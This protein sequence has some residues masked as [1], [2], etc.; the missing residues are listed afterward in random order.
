M[1]KAMASALALLSLWVGSTASAVTGFTV[2]THWSGQNEN[3]TFYGGFGELWR[4]EIANNAVTG[5]LG[6]VKPGR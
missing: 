4:H 5:T 3:R 6:S 1:T 2:T